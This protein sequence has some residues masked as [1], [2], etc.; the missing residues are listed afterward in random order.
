[1]S[2]IAQQANPNSK[3]HCDDARPQ[4]NSS[5]TLAVKAVSGSWFTN[6]MNL[7]IDIECN[8]DASIVR[9]GFALISACYVHKDE[10][11][12]LELAGISL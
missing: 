11:F 10:W 3:Y 9:A 5:S 7:P 1:M 12:R 2:S 6:G 4:F 8:A